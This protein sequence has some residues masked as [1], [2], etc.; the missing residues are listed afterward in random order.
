MVKG[1]GIV[2]TFVCVLFLLFLFFPQT[3]FT[4]KSSLKFEHF[5]TRDGLSQANINC[6]IQ[7][8]RGFMWIGSR[9]GLNK[10]DGYKFT[11]FRY[12]AKNERTLSNNMITDV[13]ED[14]D[15]NIWVATQSG[16]NMYNRNM[17]TFVRYMHSAHNPNSLTNNIL[18]RLAFD[19]NG[20]L[21]IATQN[22]GLDCF[23]IH[24]KTFQHHIHNKADAGGLA[25]DNVR[26]VFEDS[27]HRIWVGTL[28]GGLSLY[29]RSD[30][31]F[32]NFPFRE[33]SGKTTLAANVISII[34]NNNNELWVGTQDDGLFLFNKTT[35][36]FK[37]YKHDDKD[38][39]SISSNTIY[40][41]N[42]DAD[43]K[44][45]IGT[46]NGGLC[47]LDTKTG[48]F[49]TYTHDEVDNNSIN[50]NS[51]YGICSDRQGNMWL[52][53]FSGGVNLYKKTT[54]SFTLYRHNSSPASL[55]N[56]YVLA[57]FQDREK[58]IWVGTDGGGLN[59]FDPNNGTFSHYKQV[60][61]VSGGIAG[62]YV[63]VINQ[64]RDGDIWVGTWGNGI[65][66]LNKKTQKFTY[67]TKNPANPNSLLGNNVY[68]MIHT[69]DNK[70][71]ISVFGGGLDCYDK[72]TK[73]FTH[74]KLD[75]NNPKGISSNYIYSL[76]EDR[77]GNLWIGT[78]DA[79]LDLLDRKT[80]TFTHFQH[81]ETKN[82]LSNNGVTDIFEDRDGNLWLS[83][84]SGLDV[85]NPRT[86]HFTVFTKKEGLPS[87]ITYAIQLDDYGKFWIS[88]NGG[89]SA[90]DP[91]TNSFR[92][93]TTEDGIQSDEFKPHS[94]LKAQDGR[95]YFGGINGFNA[96]YPQQILKP[97]AFSP[98]VITS[99][100]LFNKPLTIAKNGSDPSP[101]KRD[102]ADTKSIIL[103]YKQSV[104]SLEYAAL[105][106]GATDKKQYTYKLE[107]F[108]ADWNFV[109]TKTTAS[110]TNL[111]PG[112]YVF[113]LR[114]QN[115][116]GLWS[117]VK[118]TLRITIV[119][120]F[121]YTWWFILLVCVAVVA[122]IYGIFK[123]RVKAIQQ[124]QLELE[125]QVEERTVLLARMTEDERKSREEAEKAREAAEKA[126]IEATQANQAKSVFL[127]TMSHEI[128]TPM[129]GVLG[130]AAL[131]N[132][133]NLD[134]EQREFSQT[135]LHSGEALLNVI[136]DILDFSKIESGKMELD[137]HNFD[138]RNCMEEVLDLFSGK[139]A[140]LGLDLIYYVEPGLP[141]DLIGDGMRLRQVLLNL[142]GNAMKFTHH[143]E[144]Y[145]GVKLVRRLKAD[146]VE[147]EFELRDTGIGIPADKL[148]KLF[149]AFSQVDSST[150]RKYGGSGL[151]LAICQRLVNLMGGD[152]IVTSSP[153]V[154]TT[155]K[156][157]IKCLVNHD[158]NT[159]IQTTNREAIKGKKV[160]V[161]DD[162]GTN[163]RI[164]QLQLEQWQLVPIMAPD[165][166]EAMRLLE[167]GLKVDFVITDMQMPDMDGIMLATAI[168]SNY[169]EMP[170]ILLSSMG[171][172]AQKNHP[173][174]FTAVL[175]KPVKPLHLE[176][177][178]IGQFQLSA[179]SQEQVFTTQHTLNKEF[180]VLKPL[181]I[182]VAE[183]NA[184]NQKMILKVLEKL[185]Y[186]AA[187]AVNG[188]EVIK[189]LDEHDYDLILM[190]VQMP[191]MDGL[192]ATRQ[193]RKHHKKQPVIIAMTANAMLEDREIC[194]KAGMNDYIAKPVKIDTLINML[195][196]TDFG[197]PV[198]H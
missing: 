90:Y 7:D 30:N 130:M 66:I 135:I 120:P 82:S 123:L 80:G 148:P 129:N 191:E 136:N 145:L 33:P 103:S 108:D 119:P 44:L 93:Y 38:A 57:I 9:N 13:A 87:D 42:K 95:L 140:E 152:I 181:N 32:A 29:N 70:T 37:Q 22:G 112:D 172:E 47:I 183:D 116:A 174:L 12:D 5:S 198:V 99:F 177:I 137:L 171:D 27:G 24:T 197:V 160:L 10:Y 18:N 196:E 179:A 194:I 133:T 118:D 169:K 190:D 141:L 150:T 134:A 78:S 126:S 151:G 6:I 175:T 101:L 164:L 115:S 176:K 83:T 52:G 149:E 188:V 96:F 54:A 55:S 104:F 113:K 88:T 97:I 86:R 182:L 166:I 167:N 105:D 2:K 142:L 124:R 68:N 84:L 193:I 58:Q 8:S 146:E 143:G 60:P 165:G 138:L 163:R 184:I 46:E 15:G 147:L 161:V 72:Q 185:G 35:K 56:D 20:K 122:I 41:L 21:W 153:A 192:E 155:F 131:L 63:L 43:G 144:I 61:G 111:P 79:G 19:H 100:Q 71:W 89:L 156:F 128:R 36:A 81:D 4:Q 65:S 11:R 158:K 91:K 75:I 154:G 64:D 49:A 162:N 127:A 94:A 31:S 180:A 170:I 17:G 34:E 23:D 168:R 67:L 186:Q 74:Y 48:R 195:R 121:W 45:W 106:Y 117:P 85:F 73:S 178:I 25:D 110:Y 189:M 50:G 39:N 109:G 107:N 14:S 53:A 173:G 132:E 187:L 159:S 77:Q 28:S 102:I 62:N 26:T 76:H 98:V 3:G 1:F 69:R 40:C 139:A 125:K 51:I 92:N 59:K 16:L 157:T 114:Y